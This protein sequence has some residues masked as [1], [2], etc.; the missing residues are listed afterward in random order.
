MK[1]F[2]KWTGISLVLIIGLLIAAPF[3][4]K[5]KIV[6]FVKELANDQLNATVDFGDFDLTLISSFPDFRLRIDNI[7][8]VGKEEFAKDTLANISR[9]GIDINLMSVINGGPYKVNSVAVDHPVAKVI[10]LESGKANYDIVKPSTDTTA[11]EES[12]EP[13]KFELSLKKL[14]INNAVISYDDKVNKLYG[15]L[16]T[17]NFELEGDFTQDVFD[18]ETLLEIERTTFKMGGV[19]YL[20]K[21]KLRFD[22]EAEVDLLNNKYTFKENEFDINALGLAF[23]GFVA[24]PGND[25]NMDIKLLTR[26]ADFKTILSLIPAIY[27]KDFEGLEAKGNVQ[28]GGFAKGTYNE[29]TYPAFELNLMVENGMFKY[30]ALPKSVNN[31]QIKLDIENKTGVLDATVIDLEKF[32]VEMAGNPV[33]ARALVK[34]PISDPNFDVKVVGTVNL[35]SIKEFIPI[36]K[37]DQMQGIIKA[38]LA[39]N[40]RLSFVEKK[41]YENFKAQGYLQAK[42][43]VYETKDLPKT[44]VSDLLLNFSNQYVELANLDAKIGNSDAK[45]NG[46]IDNFL[47]YFFKGE[48]LKGN[49]NL[50]SNTFDVNQFMSGST[51]EPAANTTTSTETASSSTGA[52]AVP[53]NIDFELKTKINRVLFQEFNFTNIVGNVTLRDQKVNLDDLQLSGFGGKVVA[54]GYYE[55]RN[56]KRPTVKLNFKLSDL[57]IQQTYKSVKAIREMVPILDQASGKFNASIDNF[58]GALDEN[59]SPDLMSINLK[60]NVHTAQIQIKAFEAFKKMAEALKVQKLSDLTLYN[61]NFN[62]AVYDGRMFINPFDFKIDKINANVAGS[63]GLDQTIDYTWKL[64]IPTEYM[65]AQ[66]TSVVTG[67]LGKANQTVGTN[68]SMPKTIDVVVKFGGTVKKPTV[69]TD[70]KDMA[71]SA[72]EQIKEEVITVVKEKVSE[73]AKKILEDAQKQVDKIKQE[74]NALI[75]K[76]KR[77][78]YAAADKLVAEAKNPL[79]K[80]AAEKAATEA[81][82]KVD[83]EILKIQKESDARSQKILDDAKQKADSIK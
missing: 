54:N 35:A 31:V 14:E 55:S 41:Q 2:L 42:D 40:G 29:K 52:V 39:L 44:S 16:D 24:L 33:D 9:I 64:T 13:F 82:K 19:T 73:E 22:S 34:T 63:T 25:V 10:V 45:A 3:I 58:T 18:L 59:M 46:R 47:Q 36:E 70:L 53:G 50:T 4:F 69:K 43:L 77:E 75:E 30:P 21:A 72:G 61:L 12:S 23:D 32:H 57:D 83:Q 11:K 62:Y 38:D 60:G 27:K 28:L 5:D 51:S 48:L 17:L 80:L 81:K 65:G 68:F 1:K 8:V 66:A 79:A 67:L 20:S 49:F 37:E 78:G 71:K 26:K 56:I 7:S 15:L 74:T 76:T 6:A